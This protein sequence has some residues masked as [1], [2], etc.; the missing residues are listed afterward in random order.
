MCFNTQMKTYTLGLLQAS[1]YRGLKRVTAE[2][3][4]AYNISTIQWA[5]LGILYESAEG[6]RTTQLAQQLGVTKPFITKSIKDLE[7][8][9]LVETDKTAH[10]DK[11]SVS[12]CLSKKGRGLVPKI[13]THMRTNMR[14]LSTGISKIKLLVYIQVLTHFLKKIEDVSNDTTQL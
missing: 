6:I 14:F 8:K 4:L 2:H 9:G 12:I 5:L 1:V 10:F 7:A 11:R 13:E 3:L